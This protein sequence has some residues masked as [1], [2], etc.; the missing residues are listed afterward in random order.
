MNCVYNEL[1]KSPMPSSNCPPKEAR[2]GEFD[3]VYRLVLHNP[4]ESDDF[5][6]HIES[7]R[8]YPPAKSCEAAAVSVFTTREVAEEWKKRIPAYRKNGF[9]ASGAIPR[10]SGRTLQKGTHINWWLY[11]NCDGAEYFSV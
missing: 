2:D 10:E 1:Y 3:L 11:K 6:S 5:L 8:T 9:I 4:P 7:G